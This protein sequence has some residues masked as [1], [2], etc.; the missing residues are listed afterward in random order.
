MARQ[1]SIVSSS[2]VSIPVS[3]ADLSSSGTVPI[4]V[5]NPAPGGGQASAN[6]TIAAPAAPIVTSV[7]P[8]TFGVGGGPIT[9]TTAGNNF[10]MNSVVQWN[11]SNLPTTY[12]GNTQLTATIPASDLISP[13]ANVPI[14]VITPGPGGGSSNSFPVGVVNPGLPTISSLNPAQAALGSAAFTLTVNG[15]N[16][17][18]GAMVYWNNISRVTNFVST[19][20]LAAAILASD[21]AL[22]SPNSASITVQNPPPTAG[23]SN[24]ASFVLENPAPQIAS[25]SPNS[26][27]AGPPVSVTI[28]GTGFISG[29]MAQLGSQ[30]LPTVYNS[31][32]SLSAEVSAV[33]GPASLTI[34][35][36]APSVGPS[37]AVTFTGTASGPGIQL[38]VANIDPNGNIVNNV[39]DGGLSSTGRYFAFPDRAS[40]TGYVRD[41]CLGGPSGCTPSSSAFPTTSFGVFEV[42]A[43][44]TNGRYVTYSTYTPSSVGYPSLY[45]ADSCLGVPS[46]CTPSVSTIADS[47]WE[48]GTPNGY[49]TPSARYITYGVG[50]LGVSDQP[51]NPPAPVEIY[52][53]CIGAA[54]GCAT[55]LVATVTSAA[56][57]VPVPSA[58]G[59]YLTYE[60]SNSQIVLHDSCLGAPAGCMVSET[61]VSDTTMTCGSSTISSDGE[62]I[63]WMCSTFQVYLQATCHNASSGCST[64]PS[65]I[66]RSSQYTQPIFVSAGGRFVAFQQFNAPNGQDEVY[67]YDSCTGGPAGCTPQSIPISANANGALA[68]DEAFLWGMSSD[69]KYVLFLSSA[70]NL[71]T[72][73]AGANGI[74]ISYIA[75]NPLF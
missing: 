27:V 25:V 31:S 68:N 55:T 46:G 37:N 6:F 48:T 5:S 70:T 57:T 33:V 62:Y 65:V 51:Q 24:A 3:S 7:S 16:F 60:N 58:D 8:N 1:A 49:I 63:A 52:D 53:T 69:G 4:A 15:T 10:V 43:T 73:P 44:S 20:Q 28:T 71:T 38:T 9:L 22:P 47:V 56:N 35:N 36:P 11:G 26:A 59:R 41:T 14:T 21:V 23:I 54:Q 40:A 29:A 13:V 32:T 39:Y 74:S 75:L 18:G 61:A 19:T 45:L 2:Q 17:V 34:T 66:A 30:V 50:V 72:I 67:L 42:F 64:T 12:V